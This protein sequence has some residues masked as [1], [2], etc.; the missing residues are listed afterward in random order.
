[1]TRLLVGF[2]HK[3]VPNFVAKLALK[4]ER[5]GLWTKGIKNEQ[6]TCYGGEKREMWKAGAIFQG[7]NRRE[8]RMKSGE[9][10]SVIK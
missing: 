6:P 2:S 4:Q 10:K 9:R 1:M 8:R 7:S 5:R 3:I